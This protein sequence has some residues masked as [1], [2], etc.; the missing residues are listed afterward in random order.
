MKVFL[1][2]CCKSKIIWQHCLE[3]LWGPSS[4]LLNGHPGSFTGVKW[5]GSK[6][7]PY[8]HVVLTLRISDDGQLNLLSSRGVG[9]T[10]LY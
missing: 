3:R 7:A 10:V 6:A 8:L 5:P 1:Y 2:N 9:L 4:L